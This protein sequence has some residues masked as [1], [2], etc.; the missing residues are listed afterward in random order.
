MK[1]V[2]VQ[3]PLIYDRRMLLS[4]RP[5]RRLGVPE[6]QAL[7]SFGSTDPKS[8]FSPRYLLLAGQPA[9]ELSFWCG[10]CP[11]LFERKEGARFG[12]DSAQSET[13]AARELLAALE[14]PLD[15]VDDELVETFAQVLPEGEYLPLLLEVEP[16]LV[17][18]ND[19]RDYFSHEQVATWGVNSF[20]GLP[21]NP[22]SFYYR[23]FETKVES[24]EHLYE[25]VVP[26]VPPSWNDR[27]RVK[28][29]RD[30]MDRGVTPTAIALSTLDMCQPAMDD[31]ST[32]YYGHWGL[33]HFLLDGHHKLEAAA[34]S[35]AKVQLLALVSLDNSLALPEHVARLAEVRAR[36]RA[37]RAAV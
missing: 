21:E 7:L 34:R 12:S 18:P 20:W 15:A 2:L 28:H 10:T 8:S 23:T 32:D 35:G 24:D 26:M 16:E 17:A 19:R 5:Q 11:L 1:C 3:A 31:D 25:F 33:S 14:Q 36:Q 37:S 27:E 29:Y 13:L 30:L 4:A 6:D 9:F 22:R